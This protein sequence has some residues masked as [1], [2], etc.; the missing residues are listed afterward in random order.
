MSLYIL[1]WAL[2]TDIIVKQTFLDI[3]NNPRMENEKVDRE[4]VTDP[5]EISND[6]AEN[7]KEHWI[8]QVVKG[9]AGM[10]LTKRPITASME[11]EKLNSRCRSAKLRVIQ[12]H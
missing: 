3:I 12:K 9:S 6:V 5:S 1:I 8:K 11:E 2:P 10:I 4:E 7:E